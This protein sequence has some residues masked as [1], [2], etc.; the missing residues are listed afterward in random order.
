MKCCSKCKETKD[1]CEFNKRTRAKDGLQN[2]CRECEKKNHIHHYARA[3]SAYVR[4]AT[5]RTSR[6]TEAYQE[7]KRTLKCSYCSEDDECCLD[8]HHLDPS[9]KEHGIARFA[10]YYFGT[11][12]WYN[13]I[14]KCIVVCSNCHRKIHKHGL[15]SMR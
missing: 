14:K 6:L 9:E 13:E 8:F 10:K 15:E 4:R 7:W 5:E 1:L 12:K 3:K 2:H 11:E